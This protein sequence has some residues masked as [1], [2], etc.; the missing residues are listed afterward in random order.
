[1][2]VNGKS[3]SNLREEGSDLS[4]AKRVTPITTWLVKNRYSTRRERVLITS[5]NDE[6]VLGRGW[7]RDP[8]HALQNRA[9]IVIHANGQ[10]LPV[11]HV[12]AVDHRDGAECGIE[13]KDC[14]APVAIYYV[15]VD[16]DAF[17]RREKS[18]ENCSHRGFSLK[19]RTNRSHELYILVK[20]RS[21][22]VSCSKPVQVRFNSTDHIFPHEKLHFLGS[23]GNNTLA[24]RCSS[25]ILHDLFV[26]TILAKNHRITHLTFRQGDSPRANVVLRSLE[27]SAAAMIRGIAIDRRI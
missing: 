16:L 8:A 22:Y 15:P 25:P 1:M 9:R 24:R 12:K 27:M 23:A 2:A 26:A 18:S 5:T 10:D 19:A 3:F 4:N 11:Y 7:S 14:G 13:I 6:G 17:Y 21:S 20:W